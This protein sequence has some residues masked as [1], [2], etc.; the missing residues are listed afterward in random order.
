MAVMKEV[1]LRGKYGYGKFAIVDDS[2]FEWINQYKWSV[3]GG[4]Y[5]TGSYGPLGRRYPVMLHRL[6]AGATEGMEADHRNNDKLD[7]QRK[8]LRVCT[9]KQN[10]M[11]RPIGVL[12]TSGHKGVSWDKS[13]K[14]WSAKIRIDG[15][16]TQIGRFDDIKDAAQAYITMAK[17]L[18][19]EFIHESLIK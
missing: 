3:N 7:N 11:N 6:L 14:K 17:E 10:M 8:N 4:G 18:H 9:P 1:V 19:G 2:D 16:P 5:V 12:N 15:K 13:R